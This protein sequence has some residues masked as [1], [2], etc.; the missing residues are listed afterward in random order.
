M[1]CKFE[2]TIAHLEFSGLRSIIV[3]ALAPAHPL[4][5][6]LRRE[7]VVVCVSAASP[8]IPNVDLDTREMDTSFQ[9]Y[10]S[11]PPKVQ[12]KKRLDLP[13]PNELPMHRKMTAN[14]TE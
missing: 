14:Y 3:C 11:T 6:D 1:F 13:V 7:G 4:D 12:E 5:E 2:A 9:P 10:T 8:R